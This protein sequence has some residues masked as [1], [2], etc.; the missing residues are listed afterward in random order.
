MVSTIRSAEKLEIFTCL[1]YVYHTLTSESPYLQ[2]SRNSCEWLGRQKLLYR[3]LD[4]LHFSIW[5]NIWRMK[6]RFLLLKRNGEQRIYFWEFFIRKT[7][8][9]F[10]EFLRIDPK[11][12]SKT[13]WEFALSVRCFLHSSI[14]Y[15]V[16]PIDLLF[17]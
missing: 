14:P 12:L 1:V 3:R 8:S 10:T 11:F 5:K 7:L 9:G 2:K 17:M 16:K 6:L 15:K 13:S 4:I